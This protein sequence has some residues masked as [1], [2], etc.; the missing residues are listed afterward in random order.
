M[1]IMKNAPIGYYKRNIGKTISIM[2]ILFSV[3]LI[4]PMAL[5]G[6][7][8]VNLEYFVIFVVAISILAFMSDV[9]TNRK[10]AEKIKRMEYLLSCPSVKGEVIEIK[11]IPYFFG[12]EIT[13]MSKTKVKLYIPA[14]NVAYRICARFNNPVT[15]E[16]EIAVSEIYSIAK[17][18]EI[19]NNTVLVHYSSD[20]EVWIEVS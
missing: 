13:N 18:K 16:E 19:K 4:L 6:A 1:D 3:A 12:K 17:I 10:N 20:G 2:V 5:S 7:T 15:G 14:K 9:V 8:F 11:S